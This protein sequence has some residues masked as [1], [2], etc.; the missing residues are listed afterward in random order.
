V[1]FPAIEFALYLAY[2]SNMDQLVGLTE[3]PRELTLAGMSA[4]EARSAG[5]RTV[6]R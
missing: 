6:S 1:V 2:P 4:K 3:E 5:F